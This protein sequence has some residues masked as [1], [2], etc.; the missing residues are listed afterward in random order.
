[1]MAGAPRRKSSAEPSGAPSENTTTPDLRVCDVNSITFTIES[2]TCNAEEMW[3]ARRGIT[4]VSLS[5]IDGTPPI[6]LTEQQP[7]MSTHI[8]FHAGLVLHCFASPCQA[9]Q[10]CTLDTYKASMLTHSSLDRLDNNG[11]REM[12][13]ADTHSAQVCRF[14]LNM[15]LQ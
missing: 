2:L 3:S 5:C 12:Q 14:Q 6:K 7:S 13:P 8:S 9:W 4:T 1:M 10:L 15:R 11:P